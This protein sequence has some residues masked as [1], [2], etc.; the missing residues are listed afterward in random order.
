M[1]G[2][3]EATTDDKN[4]KGMITVEASILIPFTLG[5]IL[6]CIWIGFYQYNKMVFTQVAA[7]SVLKGAQYAEKPNEEIIQLIQM[8]I[9]EQMNNKLILVDNPVANIEVDYDTIQIEL[10]GSM[11]VPGYIN[12]FNTYDRFGW[13]ISVTKSAN[14]IRRSQVIRTIWRIQDLS[15]NV[16]EETE[17][18]ETIDY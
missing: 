7:C 9:R 14:R 15:E 6:I 16:Y 18:Q 1:R 3:M 2:I 8:E 10:T 17:L 13:N 5:I 4:D 11:E 12:I